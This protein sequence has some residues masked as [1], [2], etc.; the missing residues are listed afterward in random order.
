MVELLLDDYIPRVWIVHV[1]GFITFLSGEVYFTST[2]V[3]LVSATASSAIVIIIAIKVS[4]ESSSRALL[5]PF[6]H[7]VLL[8]VTNLVASPASNIDA[9]SQPDSRIPFFFLLT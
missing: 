2:L 1:V 5:E 4:L 7:T 8:E 9:S 3:P 6:G